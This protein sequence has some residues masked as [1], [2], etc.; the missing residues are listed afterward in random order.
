MDTIFALSTAPGKAGVAV[1]RVSG[2]EAADAVYRIAGMIPPARR[3]TLR[4]FMDSNGGFLD[5][6][7]VI[8]FEKNRSFTGETVAEFHTH[9]SRAIISSM[10]R[11]LGGF[12]GF[13]QAEPGE[14]TLRALRN[15]RI[16]LT[17]VEGLGDLIDAETETQ[18]KQAVSVFEGALA[19]KAEA[20][21]ETMLRSVALLESELDFSEEELPDSVVPQA[22]S[23]I[24]RQRLELEG[25]ARGV[26]AAE[27]VR[28]GFEVAIVGAPNTGKSTLLNYLA[29][30][31]A[32][33]TSEYA[34][35]T[36]DIIEVRMDLGGLPV[37]LLDTAGMRDT[38]DPVERIGV[39]RA[40][41]RAESAD[42]RVYLHE[43]EGVRGIGL[44][45]G[46][47]DIVLRA[48]IDLAPDAKVPGVSGKTGQGVAGMI[49]RIVSVLGQ[50]AG[51]VGLATRE[52]HRQAILVAAAA[53]ESA[54]TE[55]LGQDPRIEIAAE[56]VWRALRAMESLVGRV[57]VEHVLDE[58]FASFCIGK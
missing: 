47:Q 41:S 35:T 28:E 5:R 6:G 56:E 4:V 27:R 33:I 48:K 2:P 46:E 22:R 40:R 13:R 20:W 58:I 38:S 32:A 12:S 9:G 44:V 7:I 51:E 50:K 54:E 29:G 19:R 34:G 21:K 23:L 26:A 15:G 11:I 16:D 55:L 1:I 14:F 10:L 52:R 42:I 17:E 3:A 39:G 45:P 31:E 49:D 57:D 37:N 8:V 25:E 18:R 53:L 24:K 36:R 43:G 30:R